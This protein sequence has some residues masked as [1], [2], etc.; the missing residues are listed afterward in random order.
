MTTY[1]T[2]D[3][4]GL[5]FITAAELDSAKFATEPADK[6]DNPRLPYGEWYCTNEACVVREVRINAKL[7]DPGDRLPEQLRCPACGK[8]LKFHHW[9]TVTT[10][11][12]VEGGLQDEQETTAVV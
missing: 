4:S 1:R 9:L 12:K 7:L 11:L 3:R 8:R 5:H 10:L 6:L 2:D